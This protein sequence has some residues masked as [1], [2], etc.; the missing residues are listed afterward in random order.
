M[1]RAAPKNHRHSPIKIPPLL[2]DL[3]DRRIDG[4]SYEFDSLI[5]VLLVP[6]ALSTDRDRFLVICSEA[7]APFAIRIVINVEDHDGKV[8]MFSS[9]LLPIGLRRPINTTARGGT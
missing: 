2:L 5:A 3:Y 8:V 1:S 7:P 9:R 6:V 4:L